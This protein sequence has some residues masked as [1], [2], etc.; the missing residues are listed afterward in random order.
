MEMFRTLDELPEGA[1]VAI[2]TF[3]G[4]HLGHRALI[5]E[6]KR[7]AFD[8]GREP[9]IVALTG[10]PAIVTNPGNVPPLLQDAAH[11]T[12]GLYDGESRLVLQPFTPA[13]ASESAED[14]AKRLQ[15]RVVFCGEDWRFGN[16]AE[17]DPQF[18]YDRG[19]DVR[20]VPFLECNGER[21][22][23]TRI[24]GCL[25]AG[26]MH[27]VAAMLGTPWDACGR[28][29]HGRGL[30]G[31]TFGVPT[32]N[33]P[34][35][36]ALPGGYRRAV[37]ACGVYCARVTVMPP[38]GND[39]QQ[40]PA[41]VNFGTAPTVKGEAEPLFEVHLIGAEGDYYGWDAEIRI[42]LPLLRAEKRFESVDALGAQIRKDLALCRQIFG[43]RQ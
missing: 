20:I 29:V 10:H 31:P 37:P 13:F 23:S 11:L 19:I 36:T 12:F 35:P 21:I 38:E 5:A 17:G 42:S 28:V 27:E 32:L 8:N 7:F 41:M 2:G 33:I 6:M 3:D 40:W 39:S 25:A 43:V 24:R 18:L 14:F 22:S 4:V 15:G 9:W 1:A 34:Y 30:A 16:G 26:K